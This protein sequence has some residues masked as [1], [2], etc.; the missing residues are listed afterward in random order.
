MS[1]ERPTSS[2]T[3]FGSATTVSVAALGLEAAL[4][5]IGA[6]GIGATGFGAAAAGI[7]A[8]T[9]R[10]IPTCASVRCGVPNT[11][12]MNIWAPTAA[13]NP[14]CVIRIVLLL[15][16]DFLRAL[17]TADDFDRWR[18]RRR[19]RGN[20]WGG[21]TRAAHRGHTNRRSH[22]HQ[23]RRLDAWCR[24]S[25]FVEWVAKRELNLAFGSRQGQLLRLVRIDEQRD[26]AHLNRLVLL[27][28]LDLRARCQHLHIRQHQT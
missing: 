16:H 26:D 17:V 22:A 6:A 11:P 5:G 12:M 20:R 18:W 3:E 13:A 8:R 24:G 28:L 19:R 4:D 9:P 10:S 25:R 1:V 27:V 7:A 23:R 2:R 15:R 21:H 14:L